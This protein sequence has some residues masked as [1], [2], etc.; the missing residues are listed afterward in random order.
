MRV[1]R[2]MW[3]ADTASDSAPDRRPQGNRET[4]P[5]ANSAK[6]V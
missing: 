2:L 3:Q 6:G 5:I 4:L 1:L